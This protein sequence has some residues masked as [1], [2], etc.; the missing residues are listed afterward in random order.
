MQELAKQT[1]LIITH[2]KNM[3]ILYVVALVMLLATF[4]LA[5]NINVHAKDPVDPV[6]TYCKSLDLS[7]KALEAC[8]N[9]ANIT[10]ARNVATYHC[11]SNISSSGKVECVAGKAS[12]YF[13][14]AAKSKPKPTTEAAFASALNKVFREVGG[15]INTPAPGFGNLDPTSNTDCSNGTCVDPAADPNTDCTKENGC[16]IIA[17]YV[18]PSINLL[19][20]LF[21]LIAAASLIMGGIQYSASEGDPQK[22]AQAKNRITN[23]IIAIVAYFFLYSFLEFLIPGG[24]FNRS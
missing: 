4:I 7:K 20:M 15:S 5:W 18:N 10:H 17:K 14:D 21:G 1:Q 16:D 3:F 22:A 24:I 6:I 13:R 23:T 19:T 11:D 9:K 8:D 12:G 2:T